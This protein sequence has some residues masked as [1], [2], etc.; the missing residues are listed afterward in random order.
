MVR[1][2]TVRLLQDVVAGVFF[3]LV[4]V[5]LASSVPSDYRA[6]PWIGLMF[7]M[8]GAA[9]LALGVRRRRRTRLESGWASIAFGVCMMFLGLIIALV[10]T[11]LMIEIVLLVFLG[12]I[13]LGF[14]TAI[15]GVVVWMKNH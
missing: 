15:A 4:A 11:D 12:M 3:S 2:T 6:E 5:A 1:I 10:P 8:V 7:G 13:C 9:F 14:I